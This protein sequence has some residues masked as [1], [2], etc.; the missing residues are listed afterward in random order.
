MDDI[1]QSMKEVGAE[2]IDAVSIGYVLNL[3]YYIFLLM[4]KS[5]NVYVTFNLILYYR[6]Y[7]TFQGKHAL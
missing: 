6:F 7:T 4:V 1:L 5:N 2:N 3:Q